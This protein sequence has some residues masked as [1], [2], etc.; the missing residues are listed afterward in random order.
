M[1]LPN[2][3]IHRRNQFIG[4]TASTEEN[5][6]FRQRDRGMAV[7]RRGHVG[8]FRKG[9]VG[10]RKGVRGIRYGAAFEASRDVVELIAL[11]G[12]TATVE[13]NDFGLQ[14]GRAV[15]DGF[16][17]AGGGKGRYIQGHDGIRADDRG[18]RNH[19]GEKCVGNR[20][21]HD[22]DIQR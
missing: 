21:N 5:D 1:V 6:L 9:Q 19:K 8:E 10:Q 4:E 7:A 11:T 12:V 17:K 3:Y 20:G 15:R 22:D 16:R 2:T 14:D 13:I 18:H